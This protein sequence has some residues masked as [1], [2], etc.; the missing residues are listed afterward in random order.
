MDFVPCVEPANS[1]EA[2]FLTD[3]PRNLMRSGN[4]LRIPFMMGYMSLESLFMI[5]EVLI[6]DSVMNQFVINPH[7]FVPLSFNLQAGS[8]AS[9]EVSTAFRQQY[10]NGAQPNQAVRFE[11]T[12]YNTDHHFAFGIDRTIRYHSTHQ[13]QPAYYY[14]FS[15]DGALNMIKRLLLLTDYPGAVHADDM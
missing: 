8:A 11:W 1:P 14:R 7:F 12:Q 15:F 10:F 2:R 13:T 5:R 3:T 9:N 4:I 6:D